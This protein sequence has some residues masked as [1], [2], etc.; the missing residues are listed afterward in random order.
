MKKL[1]LAGAFALIGATTMNAQRV[2]KGDLQANAGVTLAGNWG[3]PVYAGVDYGVHKDI[4]VGFEASYA[5]SN[6]TGYGNYKVKSNWFGVGI[7]GNYHFNTLL[8]IP[9]KWDVY[10]GLNLAY[11]HFSY[12][13]PVVMGVKFDEN[14]FGFDGSGIGFG[15]QIGARYYFTDKLGVNLQFGGGSVLDAA[16]R[17]GISYKF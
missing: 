14:T 4:T 13:F 17:V 12:D 2:E 1:M 9:N 5:S 8:N 15:A 6:L 11:N 3:V 7:N 10:A 16:G